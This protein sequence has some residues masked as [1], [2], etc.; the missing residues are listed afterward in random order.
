M[1]ATLGALAAMVAV[2]VAPAANADDERPSFDQVEHQPLNQLG[3]HIAIPGF[4]AK[5]AFT[6]DFQVNGFEVRGEH[7][8]AVG[9]LSGGNLSSPAQVAIPVRGLRENR[10]RGGPE[11]RG[12]F[13]A[14]PR[15]TPTQPAVFHGAA[16]PLV[17]TALVQQA[18]SPL[19]IPAQATQA[20]QVVNLALGAV[21]LDVLGIMVHLQPVALDVAVA[22]A[23]LVGALVCALVG[24][25]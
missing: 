24:L 18:S 12:G 22:N 6:F 2:T 4:V 23:G 10:G 16:A 1:R 9:I 11:I 3:D 20:C 25:L 8:F 13:G 19:V 21:N 15:A 17:G 5:Q 7:L 14:L